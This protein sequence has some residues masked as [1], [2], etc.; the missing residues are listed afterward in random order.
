MLRNEFN[1]PT[2]QWVRFQ[3]L[4]PQLECDLKEKK[5]VLL[6]PAADML[7]QLLDAS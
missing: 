4:M 7:I 6:S 5:N 3:V 1:L 2:H